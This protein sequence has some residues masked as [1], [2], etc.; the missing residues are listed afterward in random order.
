MKH[1]LFPD[2]EKKFKRLR[3]LFI[4]SLIIIF[5]IIFNNADYYIFK[6]LISYNYVYTKSLDAIYDQALGEGNYSGYTKNF[7]E[8]VMSVLTE[9]I[10]SI[11]NDRYTYLYNPKQYAIS[12]ENTKTEAANARIDKLSENTAYL[13][14]PNVSKYTRDFVKKNFDELNKYENIIID[15]QNN[16]GGALNSLYEIEDLFLP[17]GTTL[18]YE[19]AR[20][21]LFSR[22]I[23]AKSNRDFDFKNIYILQNDSTA[24]SAEGF[25]NALRQ[26]MDNVICVGTK[27]FG[28]GIGQ[29]VVPLTSGYAVK[30]TVI[31]VETPNNTSIHKTGIIPDIEYKEADII[32]YTFNLIENPQ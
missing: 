8:V 13:L 20:L 16:Y 24:S 26:N 9:K 15:L 27:T 17:K 12:K 19:T 7:D 2:Y 31:T 14:I 23:K 1:S 3:I 28:K 29:V 22:Q 11:D 32:D 10:R 18:G 30:A 6:F 5:A 25:I 21:G 4:M